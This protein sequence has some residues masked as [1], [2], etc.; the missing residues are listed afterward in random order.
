MALLYQRN[1]AAHDGADLR[2][3]VDAWLHVDTGSGQPGDL[4]PEGKPRTISEV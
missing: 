3:R 2:E 1:S 4:Q